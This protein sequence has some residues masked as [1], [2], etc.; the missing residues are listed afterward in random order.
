MFLKKRHHAQVMAKVHEQDIPA[1]KCESDSGYSSDKDYEGERALMIAEFDLEETSP[2]TSTDTKRIEAHFRFSL[3]NENDLIMEEV[4]LY[5]INI[6]PLSPQ[7]YKV[8]SREL[9]SEKV[10]R[11]SVIKHTGNI[12][13][14]KSIRDQI[15]IGGLGW[16]S[17]EKL[18]NGNDILNV[19]MNDIF[20]LNI[21]F[22]DDN[23]WYSAYSLD[24]I[25]PINERGVSHSQ[26]VCTL[27]N[28]SLT[29][30][31]Q[32]LYITRPGTNQLV[33]NFVTQDNRAETNKNDS[34]SKE[35]SCKYNGCEKSYFKLSHLKAHIRVHT[36][37]KPL[38]CPVPKCNQ[39]FAR[40]DE[41]SRHRRFHAGVKKFVCNYCQKAFMRSD[42]LT[43]H[44]K[45]HETRDSKFTHKSNRKMNISQVSGSSALLLN[46]LKK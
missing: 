8:E 17:R 31:Q 36:G 16:N 23:S 7:T 43:K 12:T 6:Q 45:N 39:I 2:L 35:F 15:D 3:A 9:T 27:N 5:D 10:P 20:P 21:P 25:D 1:E 11:D 44:K 41:L 24:T 46:I 40:S 26:C 30:Q 38:K 22:D 13:H 14:E 19:P 33:F 34:R 4:P 37:E 32:A 28:G 29:N 42:H 18:D